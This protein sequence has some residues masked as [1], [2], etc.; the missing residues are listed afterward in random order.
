MRRHARHARLAPRIDAET[1]HH[2]VKAENLVSARLDP[3]FG[4]RIDSEG[5][6]DLAFAKDGRFVLVPF[7]LVQAVMVLMRESS[8][9]IWPSWIPPLRESVARSVE[10][11]IDPWIKSLM[12]ARFSND[13]SFALF[14][15]DVAARELAQRARD[16]GFLGAASTD[17]VLRT[18][19]PYVYAQRFGRGKR[20]AIADE[21]G[22]SGA[23]ILARSAQA[24]SAG[25]ADPERSK[26]AR[27]WFDLDVFDDAAIGDR[28]DVAIGTRDGTQGSPVRIVLDDDAEAPE[29]RVSIATPIPPAVMVSFDPSDGA[30][31]RRIAVAAP[32][33]RRRDGSIPE[34]QIVGGSAG[35]IALVVR[36]DYSGNDDADSDAAR[37]LSVRLAQQGF[38]PSVVP[39]NHLRPADYDLLHVFGIRAAAEVETSL[40][41]ASIRPPLVITPYVDDPLREAAWGSAIVSSTLANA[42]DDAQRKMYFEAVRERR[43]ESAGHP[44]RGESGIDIR[45]ALGRAAAVIASSPEEERRLHDEFGVRE[46]RVVAGVLAPEPAAAEISSLAGCEDFVL[47]HA[48]VEPRCNQYTIVR[49]A[50]ELGFP[51]VMVGSVQDHAYYGEACAALG[52]LGI[53][54]ASEQ[55]S[56]EELA[57]LYARCRVFADVSWSSAGLQRLLRA[58]AAGA[59]LLAPGSGHARGVWPGLAQ[60]V[61]PASPGGVR[62][63]LRDA[64]RRSGELGPATA[65]RTIEVADPFKSLVTVLGAYQAAAQAVTLQS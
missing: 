37:A 35:R 36:S 53:W 27:V 38:A 60:I 49:A 52:D 59:A 28:F 34:M 65:I 16:F 32:A 47:V 64:W 6:L 30:S 57:G 44:K 63:G 54:L 22:A 45:G 50:A 62:D 11:L 21:W 46:G 31:M 51:L 48:P 58:G 15:D 10:D 25:L 8:P 29:R 12:I 41:S 42:P 7:L 26:A 40:R 24:V 3:G 33:V 39:A 2:V 14:G 55:V 43:L 5:L 13:E 18:I 19:A 20:V 4:L 56:P 9:Y 61:D 17:G 23:S 1:F